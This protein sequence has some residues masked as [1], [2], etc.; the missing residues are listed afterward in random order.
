MKLF[1]KIKLR[2]LKKIFFKKKN[3]LIRAPLWQTHTSLADIVN[4]SWLSFLLSPDMARILT[5]L[6][7]VLT[8]SQ[9]KLACSVSTMLSVYEF[10]IRQ[11]FQCIAE[12]QAY[13]KSCMRQTLSAAYPTTI[14]N[15]WK[16]SSFAQVAIPSLHSHVPQ[17]RWTPVL[18]PGSR[19]CMV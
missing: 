12:V 16:S 8:T 14:H 5:I 3:F 19:L 9:L 1:R 10:E 11:N 6:F 15:S 4:Q 17:R 2:A 13:A 18:L 7:Q